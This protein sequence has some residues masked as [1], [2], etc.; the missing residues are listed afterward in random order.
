MSRTLRISDELYARLKAAANAKGLAG[1]KQ[2]IA[3]L[4]DVARV[5]VDELQRRQEAVG[6]IDALRE[7]LFAIYGQM[8]DSVDLVRADRER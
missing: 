2:L 7:R 5:E 1:V 3:E 4:A 6:R 8:A